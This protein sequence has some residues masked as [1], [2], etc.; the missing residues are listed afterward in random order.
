MVDQTTY[1]TLAAVAVVVIL[2]L[3]RA[4]QA[5]PIEPVNVGAVLSN[6]TQAEPRKIVLPR[7]H[8]AALMLSLQ[9]ALGASITS[10]LDY[11]VSGNLNGKMTHRAVVST[12]DMGTTQTLLQKAIFTSRATDTAIQLESA[13]V[14]APVDGTRSAQK[15]FLE[16]TTDLLLEDPPDRGE[17]FVFSRDQYAFVGASVAATDG[18]K[19]RAVA[20]LPTDQTVDPGTKY[21]LTSPGS[22][23][24]AGHQPPPL[25][26]DALDDLQ[27]LPSEQFVDSI[28]V[29][30]SALNIQYG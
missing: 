24:F 26:F 8:V 13:S 16:S 2:G 29:Q 25:E 22:F 5:G 20:F 19:Q 28:S 9:T 17:S 15:E 21:P 30:K 4:G 27:P 10:V 14:V 1:L 12:H 11:E 6:I 18:E 3:V 23:G 7:D